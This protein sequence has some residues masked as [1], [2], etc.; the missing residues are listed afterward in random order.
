MEAESTSTSTMIEAL[1]KRGWCIG[2]MDKVNAIIVIQSALHKVGDASPTVDLIESE[3]CN[4]DL[5][6]IGAKSLPDS[7]LLRNK[8]TRLLGP[9]VLQ[10]FHSSLSL[11]IYTQVTTILERAILLNINRHVLK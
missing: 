6:S 5:K 1:I 11:F 9:K 8:S 7:S 2:D 4:M 3:L 10:A